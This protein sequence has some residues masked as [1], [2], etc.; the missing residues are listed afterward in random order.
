VLSR[1]S[2]K[3]TVLDTGKTTTKV[4]LPNLVAFALN[5]QDVAQRSA[6]TIGS[7]LSMCRMTSARLE[8]LTKCDKVARF[9]G[10][11]KRKTYIYIHG[12]EVVLKY[13][14]STMRHEPPWPLSHLCSTSRSST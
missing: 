7:W 4:C 5:T 2:V 8:D 10:E 11:C 3:N 1:K 12:E 13:R 14:E 6:L 9:S